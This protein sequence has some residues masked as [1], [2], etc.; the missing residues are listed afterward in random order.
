MNSSKTFRF[1]SPAALEKLNGL[2]SL[3]YEKGLLTSE[4]Y[5]TYIAWEKL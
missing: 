4:M 1:L 3:T 5:R 2:H